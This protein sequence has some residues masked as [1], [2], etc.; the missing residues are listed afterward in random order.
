M[1][2]EALRPKTC[3][4][5]GFWLRGDLA[6]VEQ[7]LSCTTN[8][9]HE[10]AEKPRGGTWYHRKSTNV[11]TCIYVLAAYACVHAHMKAEVA[12]P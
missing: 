2:I 8:L 12:R 7:R 4:V 6:G 3:C 9:W 11:C 10:H 5:L 1:R